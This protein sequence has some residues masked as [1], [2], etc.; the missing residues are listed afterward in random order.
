MS[1]IQSDKR[2]QFSRKAVVINRIA[3]S[4]LGAYGEPVRAV[5]LHPY[6]WRDGKELEIA[7]KKEES[8]NEFEWKGIKGKR[9]QIVHGDLNAVADPFFI[10]MLTVP[11]NK[12]FGVPVARKVKMDSEEY[13][14]ENGFESSTRVG[15]R[16]WRE[17]QEDGM[18]GK[19]RIYVNEDHAGPVMWSAGLVH[20][21]ANKHW[22]MYRRILDSEWDFIRAHR[23]GAS[24]PP[25]GYTGRTIAQLQETMLRNNGVRAD[26]DMAR[27]M[28]EALK[29]ST[30][31]DA[32]RFELPKF[33]YQEH[34]HDGNG[35]PCK[36]KLK[37]LDLPVYMGRFQLSRFV[38]RENMQ[39]VVD[40]LP[41]EFKGDLY[42]FLQTDV[43]WTD[44][45]L[46]RDFLA[47][48][49]NRW[50]E[51]HTIEKVEEA[52]EE[53]TT[54]AGEKE[55]VAPV[56]T[57]RTESVEEHQE[58]VAEQIIKDLPAPEKLN[59]LPAPLKLGDTDKVL[60]E[61][62]EDLSKRDEPTQV[63]VLTADESKLFLSEGLAHE[64]GTHFGR[65]IA[66]ALEKVGVK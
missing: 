63:P 15:M 29:I 65:H 8:G 55:L 30:F 42:M 40:L 50:H 13:V 57:A 4:M 33:L 31:E 18:G 60:E 26:S 16:S 34:G 19:K 38:G 46:M 1:K 12:K 2:R 10:S 22:P 47:E 54:S 62:G 14:Y 56:Q 9:I 6:A 52:L 58:R 66:D 43:T 48:V 35:N 28:H 3:P 41:V 44:A 25:E 39:Q 17:M 51:R 5:L 53:V 23:R 37:E 32:Q 20:S 36:G 24:N 11:T 59:D 21:E 64:A 61:L 27:R 7:F 45:M 49:D